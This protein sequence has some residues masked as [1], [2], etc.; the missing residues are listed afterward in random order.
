MNMRQQTTKPRQS[1]RTRQ[2]STA[3]LTNQMVGRNPERR[4][5]RNADVD[6]QGAKPSKA[7]PVDVRGGVYEDPSVCESCTSVFTRR[8]W[9]SDRPITHAL[10]E[11]AAWTKCPAC[12]QKKSGI[13][14][15]RVVA[16][17]EFDGRRLAAMERRIENVAARAG[18]TQPQRAIVSMERTDNGLDVLTTSQK[19]AHRIVHELKKA[20][21]GRARYAWHDRDGSLL[22]TWSAGGQ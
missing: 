11:K 19:L 9:R 22:A 17:G 14:Y 20:F 6:H 16:R 18:Y 21:G 10:L 3:G 5:G 7:P 13:A 1:A 4:P 2:R 8:T 12:K 15:G